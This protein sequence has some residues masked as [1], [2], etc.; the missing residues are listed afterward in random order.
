MLRAVAIFVVGLLL[1]SGVMWAFTPAG[2]TTATESPAGPQPRRAVMAL[3][4]IE[5]RDGIV[6][7]SSPLVGYQV[8]QVHVRDGQFV[9]A[10]DPLVDLDTAAAEAEYQ[11][12][13][14][15]LTEAQEG[16]Q[17]KITLGKERVAT[18][19]LAVQQAT[20]GKELEL[21]AQQSRIKL[22]AAKQKQAGKDLE[23]VQELRKLAEPLA[24]EQQVEQARVLVEAAEAEVEAT[25]VAMKRLEQALTFQKQTAAAELRAA[26]Q[27]L[28]FAEKG[29][30]IASLER[31]VE[32]AELKRKQTKVV[33]T[34]NGVV[35]NVNVR[36]G[37]IVAQQPLLQMADLDNLVCSVEVDAGDVPFLQANQPALV[38]CRAFQDAV[39]DGTVDRV[40][41]QV[42]QASLRPLDPRKPVDRNATKVTVSIDAKKAARLINTSGNDRRPALIGLQVDVEFPLKTPVE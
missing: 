8:L 28:A 20:D 30:G 42:A 37:E 22:A 5:P 13:A 17:A 1:G 10:G 23:K 2:V 40:G 9:K 25:N 4:T 33:A 32:L 38:R 35:L 27:S 31:R 12:A 16:Q 24:T 29:T 39:L 14:S 21:A 26:Q 34:S 19:E 6:L 18:A 15:Q 41:N 7:V 11:L 3:G 36:A